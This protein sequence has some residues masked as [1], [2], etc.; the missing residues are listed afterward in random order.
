LNQDI[1]RKSRFLR[2]FFARTGP[3]SAK[4]GITGRQEQS[5][6]ENSGAQNSIKICFSD[7]LSPEISSQMDQFPEM[8]ITFVIRS[9][10]NIPVFREP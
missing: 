3:G 4:S 10:E 7:P 6:N 2:L 8:S 5:L 9:E 1:F